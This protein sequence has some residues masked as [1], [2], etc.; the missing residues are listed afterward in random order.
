MKTLKVLPVFR[1]EQLRRKAWISARSAAA[2]PDALMKK[3][4][5]AFSGIE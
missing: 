4:L 2:R 1:P 5:A 3:A